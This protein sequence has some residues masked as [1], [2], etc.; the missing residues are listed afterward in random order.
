VACVTNVRSSSVTAIDITTGTVA[1]T[2]PVGSCAA[3]FSL[4]V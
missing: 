4:S 3:I 2:V 1:A